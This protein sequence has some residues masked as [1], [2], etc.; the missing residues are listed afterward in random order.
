[1]T[2]LRSGLTAWRRWAGQSLEDRDP[3]CDRREAL[4][5]AAAALFVGVNAVGFS[6]ARDG[7]VRWA[8]LWAPL[9][10]LA[11]IVVAHLLLRSLKPRRDPFL[12]P[13]FALLA[14][15]GLLLQD[16]LAANFL[17]RQT[18]WLVLSTGVLLAVALIPR[19]LQSLM[20]YRYVL[21]VAGLLLLGVT[22]LFGVNPSGSGAALWL[23]VP[24]PVLGRVYFQPSELLKVLLVIF[25]ASYFTELEPLYRMRQRAAQQEANQGRNSWQAFKRQLPFLGPL[26]LMWGFCM[27]L[28]VWQQDLGAA[29]LF[30]IVF[31]TLLYLAT[32]RPAYVAAGLVML[33]AA[34]VFAYFAFGSVA[35]RVLSWL[36]PWPNASDRA[37][38]IVQSLYALAA[39]GVLGEG[40]GLGFPDYIPVVHSDFALAAI[41]EEW[42]LVGSLTVVAAFAALATR[43]L[44]AA[45]LSIQSLRPR[46]FHTYLAAGL[47]ALFSVQALLIMGG[48]TKLLPLTGITLP[49]VSY[50]GSSLL[51]SS[52]MIGLL[53]FLSADTDR[54]RARVYDPRLARRLQ[55]LGWIIL[56]A[57]GLVALTLGYWSIVRAEALLAREDNPRLVETERRV[58]R[59]RI[60]D[61]NGVV[62]A[63]S[64]GPA[65]NLTRSYPRPGG[66]AV[67]YYSIRFG[68]GGIEAALD[69]VLR[70]QATG[71][72]AE[73]WRRMIH[74]PSVGRDVRLTIDAAT[75]EQ[76]TTLMSEH[77]GALVLLELTGPDAPQA[78]IR[79][80]VSQPGYDPN[81]LDERFE[82]LAARDPG[83]LFNRAAQG[84]YQPGLT[85][86]PLIT[87]ATLDSGR[88][89]LD[90]PLDDPDRPVILDGQVQR[91]ATLP[92]ATAAYTWTDMA[93]L[94]C[95]APLQ[96]LGV[97][98]GEAA[99][100]DSFARF[101]LTTAPALPIPTEGATDTLVADPGLAAIG[102]ETLTITPLQAALAAAALAGDGRLPAPR[103]VD[104][105][106][107]TDGQW[108]VQTAGA[109]AAQ[110]AV[111]AATVAAVRETWPLNGDLREYAVSVLSGPGGQ[112]DAWYLA[113]F[114]ADEPRYVLALVLEDARGVAAAETIG[115]AVF[116]GLGD[117]E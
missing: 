63:E 41:A 77:A 97:R 48:V 4:L 10:W 31:M 17:G 36:N 37:Y 61:R 15:W 38:Q 85:L 69:P 91:C 84:L 79:A 87:A 25:L 71:V 40:I 94:R 67:G 39:G 110:T 90:E 19:T 103:L 28:L 115:R 3:T 29:A 27:L 100:D 26:G 83:P 18:L 46:F 47:V 113:L 81:G 49:F 59:G 86:Q 66:P 45:L 88:L 35:P 92:A 50:G 72:W 109:A 117:R 106:V 64:V 30:F 78:E 93:V 80:M 16:R 111:A 52:V 105:V 51:I 102:Q 1:M 9:V 68:A 8:H 6:L 74:A 23:P 34:S 33:L 62:L 114:P 99:L 20:R 22:L 60:L 108:E 76:A 56:A 32:G 12:L 24:F 5:L 89:A 14:G 44:R 53:I 107:G 101:G 55:R 70:G 116:E 82:A 13:L 57:Y 98:L 65:D 2:A 43:G 7:V 54:A 112:R 21:L 11:V 42:G 73:A 95:P 96:D 104:A 75:Q 58:R